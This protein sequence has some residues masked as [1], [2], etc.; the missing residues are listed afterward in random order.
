MDNETNRKFDSV[1]KHGILTQENQVDHS[2]SKIKVSPDK[3]KQ[4]PVTVSHF[5]YRIF[6]KTDKEI[7][8]SNFYKD[9]ERCLGAVKGKTVH[10]IALTRDYIMAF[11]NWLIVAQF[12]TT[13][14]INNIL[15]VTTDCYV[16]T[17]LVK[18]GIPVVFLHVYDILIYP[19]TPRK[20]RKVGKQTHWIVRLHTWRI[21]NILGYNVM[22]YDLDSLP[23]RNPEILFEEYPDADIIGQAVGNYPHQ[24]RDAWMFFTLNMGTIFIR[25][26]PG[27][28]KVWETISKLTEKFDRKAD[29]QVFMNKALHSMGLTWDSPPIQ[30]Y[31]GSK[32]WDLNAK[33][34]NEF[35]FGPTRGITTDGGVVVIG[36]PAS[37]FC[38]FSCNLNSIKNYMIW[39]YPSKV[40]GGDIW[41]LKQD[42]ARITLDSE[43]KGLDWLIKITNQEELRRIKL[44]AA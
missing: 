22:S 24:V 25:N 26:T 10:T 40:F 18:K 33:Q 29:D 43:K 4:K 13:P 37:L 28:E 6:T 12:F 19:F 23:L 38:R 31:G 30:L 8:N 14:P 27:T 15:I 11:L 21:I 1:F 42:W 35:L 32:N 44:L 34:E 17:F 20:V 9:L 39:H 7:Q 2:Y 16:Y 3:S 36:V 5:T 41:F